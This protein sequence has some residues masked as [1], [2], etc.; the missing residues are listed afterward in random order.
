VPLSRLLPGFLWPEDQFEGGAGV[1]DRVYATGWNAQPGFAELDL[2]TDTEVAFRLPGVDGLE[3]VLGAPADMTGPGIAF[4]AQFAWGDDGHWSLTLTGLA[5][6]LR[7][8]GD[9]LVAMRDDGQGGFAE[10]GEP[11]GITLTGDLTLSDDWG[12][13][14]DACPPV[15]LPPAR[16][17]G[18]GVIV[19]ADDVRFHFSAAPPPPG[20][21]RLQVVREVRNQA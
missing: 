6:T 15:E 3:L 5:A 14:F 7:W 16:I 13:S 1:L 10:T 18:T 2:F 8:D 11:Y 19:R 12:L 4:G 21:K 17:G 20:T 9:L